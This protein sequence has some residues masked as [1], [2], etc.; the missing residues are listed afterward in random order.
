M[1]STVLGVA[2]ELLDQHPGTIALIGVLESQ[3]QYGVTLRASGGMSGDERA[4]RTM[5]FS[6]EDVVA[7]VQIPRDATHRTSRTVILVTERT[8][9]REIIPTEERERLAT[10]FLTGGIGGELLIPGTLEGAAWRLGLAVSVDVMEC[11]PLCSLPS[12]SPRC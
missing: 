3:E 5:T 4:E 7:Q 11:P 2:T 9:R 8:M 10:E 6:S 12:R 1:A